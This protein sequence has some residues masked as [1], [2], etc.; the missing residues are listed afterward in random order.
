MDSTQDLLIKKAYT[1]PSLRQNILNKGM[2]CLY[3]DYSGFVAQNN[4]GIA[5]CFVY[6]RTISI[7]AKK[8]LIEHD[9]GSIYGELQAIVYSLEI[10][11]KALNE[12][13]PKLA[14]LFTDCSCIA[15][16]LSKHDFSHP[17]YENARYEILA[18][19]S[20]LKMMFPEV[21]V[22]VKYISNHKKDN[23][24]HRMAHNA[25][26]QAATKQGQ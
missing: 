5:C 26:R 25:A 1:S 13:Q 12:H 17:Y 16:I 6:N 9:V 11:A 21:E 20:N 10:L 3:C 2:I 18:S 19:M 8:L 15:K 4:Y 23:V 14:I 22:R 7:T 24:L